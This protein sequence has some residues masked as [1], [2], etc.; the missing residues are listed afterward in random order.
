[1]KTLI[2]LMILFSFNAIAD[3]FTIFNNSCKDVTLSYSSEE[4]TEVVLDLPSNE[5]IEVSED[6]L[7]TLTISYSTPPST[8][9]QV[10]RKTLCSPTTVK[11]TPKNQVLF[12]Q[13]ESV[14]EFK[15]TNIIFG[16]KKFNQTIPSPSFDFRF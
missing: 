7:E 6:M 9:G 3:S 13:Y 1:M 12:R 2:F 15:Y 8:D 16:C 10:K 5:N 14:L 11:C 4:E